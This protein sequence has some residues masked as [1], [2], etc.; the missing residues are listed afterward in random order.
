MTAG[1]AAADV[2]DGI[3]I[4]PV[5]VLDDA[6]HG[7]DLAAALSAGGIRTA[8]ITL[9]TDAG[10]AAIGRISAA[11]PDFVVGAGTVLTASDVDRAVDAGA[12]YVVSPGWDDEVIARAADRGVVALPGV[13][14]A[15][16]LQRAAKSGLDRVKFF[17]AEQAGGL[18]MIE[19]LR[20]PFPAVRFLPS[21][22]VTAANAAAYLASPAVFAV[23][24][25]WMASRKAIAA[26][27]WT[28]IARAS[29][30]AIASIPV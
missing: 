14:T 18:P 10:L 22:G 25:S 20:G 21:G 26:G 3:P 23:S 6:A 15:T 13:A 4:V 9:R 28:G 19:A 24:G 29:A 17:P 8:E 5:I 16:E 27:D 11:F 30:D 12:R 2:L 1:T 7:P